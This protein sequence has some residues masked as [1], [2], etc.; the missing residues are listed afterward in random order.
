MELW[1]ARDKTE[2]LSLFRKNLFGNTVILLSMKTGLMEIF[3][4]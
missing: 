2:C 4:L 1:I 3:W